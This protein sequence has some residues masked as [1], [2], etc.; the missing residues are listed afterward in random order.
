MRKNT[1]ASL[2][3]YAKQSSQRG[4]AIVYVMCDVEC[5]NY[6]LGSHMNMRM[7]LHSYKYIYMH[8]YVRFC[9]QMKRSSV[10]RFCFIGVITI[11]ISHI[12]LKLGSPQQ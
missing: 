2:V 10:T 8:I 12:W 4:S 5:Y 3:L 6:V 9:E 7:R 11:I 1:K